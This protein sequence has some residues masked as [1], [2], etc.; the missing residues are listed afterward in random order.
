M[1]AIILKSIPLRI[2][3]YTAVCLLNCQVFARDV[4]NTWHRVLKWEETRNL[5][6]NGMRW[7]YF[8]GASHDDRSVPIYSEVILLNP[9]TFSITVTIENAQYLLLKESDLPKESEVIKSFSNEL[10]LTYSIGLRKKTPHACVSIVPYRRTISGIERLISFDLIIAEKGGRAATRSSHTF[11]SSSVLS[12]G[13]W[14]KIGTIKNGIHKLSYQYLKNMGIDID[15]IDPRTLRL[16]GNGAGMLPMLNSAPRRDD[17]QENAIYV[18]GESDGKFDSGDYILFYGRE[19]VQ[20]NYSSAGYIH[21]VNDYSDTTYYFI[22]L[23]GVGKRIPIR[24]SSSVP[25]NVNVNSYDE[26]FEHEVNASNVLKSGRQW[27]GEAF[28][29]QNAEITWTLSVPNL[30]TSDSIKVNAHAI[31]RTIT[32]PGNLTLK[33]NGSQIGNAISVAA[34]SSGVSYNYANTAFLSGNGFSSSNMMNVS[35]LFSSTDASGIGQLDYF[36]LFCRTGLSFISAESQFQFRDSRSIGTGNV[37]EFIIS[38]APSSARIWDVT[39]PLNVEEQQFANGNGQIIFNYPTD[40]LREYV[41]FSGNYFAPIYFGEVPNQNLHALPQAQMVIVTHPL[42]ITQ[43]NAIANLHRNNDNLTVHVVTINQIFNEFSSGS[44]DVSAIRDFMKMFY[45]RSTTS[46]MP[47]YLLLFGDASY[48]NKHRLTG[49]TNFVT[50]YQSVSSLNLT[51]SYISDDFFGLL[52][53]NEGLWDPN[54]SNELLDISVGRLPVKSVIEAQAVT[55]K[56]LLYASDASGGNNV[57]GD[58]RNNVTFVADDQDNNTHFN[59]AEVLAN[60]V[61]NN[62]PVYNIDKIYLDAYKQESTPGGQ[63]FPEARNAIVS[64]VERGTLLMSYIGHG[65]EVG[66]AHERVLEVSDINSWTNNKHLAAVL[67]ATCEFT[68]VDDPSRSSA[69]ELVILN[70]SG[71]AVCLFSTSRLAYS[72]S[73]F[74]LAQKFFTHFFQSVNGVMPTCG[75]VFEKTKVDY[76][77]RYTRNFLLIGDPALRLAYPKFDVV[78]NTVNS[79]PVSSVSDTLSALSKVTITGEVRDKSG[80]KLTSFNGILYPTVYDKAVTYRTLGND[81][82]WTGDGGSDWPAP[83]SL[84]KNILYKG[85][86]KITNGDFSFTFI[87]PKDIAYQYGFGKLSYYAENGAIDA[88]G[89]YTNVVIGGINSSA[90]ADNS[91]PEIKVYMND[92]KFV[93]GGMTDADPYLYGVVRD[94]NGIN[95]VGNGIG[96]DIISTLDEDNSNI[97]VLNDYYE[98]D[99]DNYQ[100]GK[101]KYPFHDLTDGRHSLKLKVWDVYNNSSEAR[102]EF[103]V[104]SAAN[105]ALN[106]VLN[107][108]NPFTTHTTFMFEHNHPYSQLKTQIQIFTVSGKLI[109]TLERLIDTEGYRS[110]EIEW[111]GLDDY[112]D[113]IGKGVYLYKVHVMTNE[114][115]SAEKFEKL[116]ILR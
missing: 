106:H 112:G 86:A 89:Y 85:K 101:V 15:N 51:T 83:F 38:N 88:N 22:T 13:N 64:K 50:S 110:N 47:K 41:A 108:P 72:G 98:A 48:D 95:T 70:P 33:L 116:V 19:Q 87:V 67:T 36:E 107:Y 97:S 10:I 6:N 52:D 91:G 56:I 14:H 21:E 17:L 30:L 53:D 27:F 11:A 74:S 23:G 37:G 59:Q 54:N 78:T 55:N 63:R 90:E 80:N 18:E 71:G 65:G 113:R 46:D 5:S 94:A 102:T 75:E 8:A 3:L 111:N 1:T 93:F 43:A 96:H 57:F 82:G 79:N 34:T 77:D 25:A 4:S 29:N 60:S 2:V 68:R 49:N 12:S 84:Q 109:K 62:Y 81:Q 31:S 26:H 44:Q 24:S 104:A 103:V 20:W 76:N 100:S 40:S 39:D 58:W 73:N 66:W 69:G 99:I 45:D 61:R 28:D 35:L 114:G 7:G 16:Y 9:N 42:F 115:N 105:L 92:E 32:Y